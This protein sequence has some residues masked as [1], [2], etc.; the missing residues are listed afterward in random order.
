MDI[1]QHFWLV[2]DYDAKKETNDS[3]NNTNPKKILWLPNIK[4]KIRK[5]FKKVNKNITFTSGKNS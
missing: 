4:P 1:R 2:K 5:E 3:C